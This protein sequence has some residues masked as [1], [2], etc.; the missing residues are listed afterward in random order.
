MGEC[1]FSRT[2]TSY[3]LDISGVIRAVESNEMQDERSFTSSQSRHGL[4][5]HQIRHFR[6]DLKKSN[7]DNEI[8]RTG[9]EM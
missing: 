8:A 6:H 2:S 5:L 1:R 9:S 7:S 4:D 3:S